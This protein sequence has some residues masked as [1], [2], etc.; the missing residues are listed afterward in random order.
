MVKPTS[1]QPHADLATV[2]LEESKR[3]QFCI[4][5]VFC[6]SGHAPAPPAVRM[7]DVSATSERLVHSYLA[8]LLLHRSRKVLQ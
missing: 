6:G 1:I 8:Q 4:S 2:H 7:L 5:V 3:S